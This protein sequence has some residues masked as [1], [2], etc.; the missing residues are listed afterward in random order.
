MKNTIKKMNK[1]IKGFE[2][3]QKSNKQILDHLPSDG[4]NA[5]L[6]VAFDD[7]DSAYEYCIKVCNIRIAKVR[8]I[9]RDKF[10]IS[11]YHDNF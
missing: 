9:D 7:L 10:S 1:V 4:A 6:R 8:Q 11:K 5:D 3:M 2:K